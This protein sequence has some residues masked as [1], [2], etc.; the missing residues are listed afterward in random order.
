MF[1]VTA[2]YNEDDFGGLTP[3]EM[4]VYESLATDND[5]LTDMCQGLGSRTEPR[6]LDLECETCAT[7]VLRV[8]RGIFG[9]PI[10]T[11]F[12][13]YGVDE[14]S[15]GVIQCTVC[16]L[17]SAHYGQVVIGQQEGAEGHGAHRLSA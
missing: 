8:E 14:E 13:P 3:V 4:T 9:D 2:Y 6:Y 1:T 11:E 5:I 10:I 7:L 12:R 17:K 16:M 15:S